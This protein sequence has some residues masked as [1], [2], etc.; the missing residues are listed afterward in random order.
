MASDVQNDR[1]KAGLK[2]SHL[3]PSHLQ[4]HIFLVFAGLLVLSDTRF[5]TMVS[6]AD[7]DIS[8]SYQVLSI[9][10]SISA[11]AYIAFG[12]FAGVIIDALSKRLFILAH[13]IIFIPVTLAMFVAL[14]GHI[15]GIG[16]LVAFVVLNEISSAFAKPAA[17]SVYYGM[18]SSDRASRKLS[19]LGVAQRAGSLAAMVALY[20][21]AGATQDLFLSYAVTVA[22]A[23]AAYL[24]SGMPGGTESGQRH[25]IRLQRIKDRTAAFLQ[26][27]R[28]NRPL[29]HL[30]AFTFLKTAFVFW[31][32]FVG[33]LLKFG[34]EQT[35]TQ[36]DFVIALMLMQL[37]LMTSTYLFGFKKTFTLRAVIAGAT[38]S[39]VSIIALALST[40]AWTHIVALGGIYVGTAFSGLAGSY[41]MRLELP[42]AFRT[43]GLAFS[44]LPFYAG[45][46]LGG[47]VS[48]A[49]LFWLDV[50]SL[51]LVTG[52]GLIALCAV[53]SLVARP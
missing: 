10:P 31:P 13:V 52:I 44:I 46:I 53:Y 25:P 3:I 6:F 39:A 14:K 12:L 1:K 18:F 48:A 49:L 24:C 41:I 23:L 50:D 5:D 40:Q 11:I 51:L 45:D 29:F 7:F 8:G 20:I 37:V 34:V 21:F 2:P 28:Q 36:R 17:I 15:L 16:V 19:N 43:Q 47:F 30:F 26:L 22:L 35:E 42:E 9:I 4:S 38:F 32:M 33:S 27:I